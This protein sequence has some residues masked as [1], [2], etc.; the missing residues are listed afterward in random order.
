LDERKQSTFQQD[1]LDHETAENKS[2]S[3][4]KQNP[5]IQQSVYFSM[6]LEKDI[7]RLLESTNNT[8]LQEAN[9]L[10][11]TVNQMHTRQVHVN[12]I[13]ILGKIN[14]GIASSQRSGKN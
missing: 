4:Q 12:L 3:M 13:K 5:N 7:G 10:P 11:K 8:F 9:T 6:Q 14:D 1:W 2:K